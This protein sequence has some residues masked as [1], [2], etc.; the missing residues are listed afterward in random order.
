M[1]S[2]LTRCNGT[3]FDRDVQTVHVFLSVLW[4]DGCCFHYLFVMVLLRRVVGGDRSRTT[5]AWGMPYLRR[6]AKAEV[7]NA[8][9]LIELDIQAVRVKVHSRHVAGAQHAGRIRQIALTE[10]L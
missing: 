2:C 4:H 7:D 10:L 9:L 5:A 6:L 8:L 3:S 1:R